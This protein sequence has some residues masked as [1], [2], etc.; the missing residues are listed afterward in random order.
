MRPPVLLLGLSLPLTMLAAEEK[1]VPVQAEPMHQTVFENEYVRVI[2]VQIP[3][4]RTTL[5]H[6]HVLP[7]VIVYLTQSSNRSESWPDK[8]TLVREISPGQSRF[9]PYDEK[10]LSHR[11]TN[12]SVGLFRV[13]D[14]EFLKKPS[15]QPVLP[16]LEAP[17][18]EVHWDEK[19]VRSSS[20]TLEPNAEV[21]LAAHDCASL[22]VA[23]VG[24]LQVRPSGA[25][26]AKSPLKW[27]DFQF[28]PARTQFTVRNTGKDKA[29]AVL[30]EL[31]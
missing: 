1:P 29:E 7:S 22:I 12:T 9:A 14:I 8:E 5:F 30:L 17:H 16:A 28:H 11:V 27:G 26:P 2:D 20:I 13:F 4:G 10:P 15:G 21:V 31:K 18:I 25:V 6:T 23:I 3:P 24:T 19:L